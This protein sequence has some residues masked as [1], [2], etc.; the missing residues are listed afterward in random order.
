VAKSE[1]KVDAVRCTHDLERADRSYQQ[2]LF[3]L[4][5]CN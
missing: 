5:T 3:L 4:G 2:L 1:K